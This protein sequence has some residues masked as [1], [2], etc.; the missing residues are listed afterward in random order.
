M[1]RGATAD[2][3][4]DQEYQKLLA[5]ERA[6]EKIKKYK[7]ACTVI[8]AKQGLDDLVTKDGR[9]VENAV[10]FNQWLE[11]FMNWAKTVNV[12]WALDLNTSLAKKE[13]HKK[14]FDKAVEVIYICLC[15]AVKSS[16][17]LAV[18][19]D[20]ANNHD[21]CKALKALKAYFLKEKDEI[22]LEEIEEDLQT[23]KPAKNETI[24]SWLNRIKQYELLLS[25]TER[26]KTDS[27]ML[28]VIKRNLPKEF[29]DFKARFALKECWKREG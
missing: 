11:R 10:T 17:A 2:S 29:T 24:E 9:P 13:K 6:K 7:L 15:S 25:T 4:F 27:E 12:Y 20:E 14:Q 22:N 1:P 26:K 21:V 18:V 3:V 16:V 23:C 5:Q 28:T 19:Q 8:E